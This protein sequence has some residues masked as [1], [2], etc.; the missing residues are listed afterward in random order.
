MKY[1]LILLLSVSIAAIAFFNKG[2]KKK[3]QQLA[4]TESVTEDN[5]DEP[6]PVQLSSVDSLQH[7]VFVLSP[8]SPLPTDRNI[9]YSPTLLF[10]WDE[11]E[12]AVDSPVVLTA[13]SSPDFQ[14]LHG[15]AG[16]QNSL[17]P[18]EYKTETKIEADRI[19][20]RAFFE[21]SLPF[22][23]F[24]ISNP[25]PFL[26][27]NTPVKA[28]GKTVGDSEDPAKTKILYY[29]S[30]EKFI[31]AL[32]PKD[33][34]Q[35]IV[36]CKGVTLYGSFRKIL[37]EADSLIK[38]GTVESKLARNAWK[39][40][41]KEKDEL[42]IPDIRFNLYKNYS[43]ITGQGFSSGNN[44]YYIM[45]AYQQTAFSL[46]QRG[47]IVASASELT[48]K[49]DVPDGFKT[50][51]HPKKLLLDK[52]FVLLLRN[53]KRSEPYFMLKVDNPEIMDKTN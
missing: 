35:E 18:G 52:P 20:A 4:I 14:M 26:Y 16:Y 11:I 45:T 46:N 44:L 41:L 6:V 38:T 31:V 42:W 24:Y 5:W 34:T 43:S 49:V 50:R 30:D 51:E 19:T 33:S 29:H 9:A 2:Y 12:K 47:A 17:L 10:A 15:S 25:M 1:I 28:F 23:T 37:T 32:I 22:S 13:K 21:K 36:V 8:D 7:T 48:V 40:I 53:K 39:Y 27:R 3:S